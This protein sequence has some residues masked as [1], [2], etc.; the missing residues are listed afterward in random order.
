MRVAVIASVMAIGSLSGPALP[1]EA[2]ETNVAPTVGLAGHPPMTWIKRTPGA[3]APLKPRMGYEASMGWDAANG[4]VF[5]WDGHNQGGGGE[6][7]FE[8]WHHDPTRNTWVLL[9][10]NTS[11]PGNC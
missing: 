7:S 6:Q 8:T 10:T 3:G 2:A 5:R 1:E 4:F 11:L 9:E